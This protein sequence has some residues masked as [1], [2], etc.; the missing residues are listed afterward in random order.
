M[1]NWRAEYYA[2]VADYAVGALGMRVV[3][4]GGRSELER[5]VGEAIVARMKQPVENNIGQDTLLQLLATLERATI[6]L[7]PDSGPAHMA[8]AVGT[9]VIGLYA[10]TNPARSGPYLSRQW[11]VDKYDVAARRLL[12]KPAHELPWTTKIERPG[13]MDLITPDEVIRKLHAVL[14]ALSCAST[15]I[16]SPSSRALRHW[17]LPHCVTL[18]PCQRAATLP[19]TLL[20]IARN[21]AAHIARCLA[22]VPFAAEKLVVD[23][24]STDG[25]QA[26]AARHGARVVE[27]EWLGFGPQRNFAAHASQSRLDPV[28]DADEELTP[29]LARELQRELAEAACTR[30][31]PARSC[32]AKRG[33]WA[34]RCAGIDRWSARARSALSSRPRALDRC[35]RA[36][37]VALRRTRRSRSARPFVIITTRHSYTSSSRCCCTRSS[38][39]SI[40]WIASAAAQMWLTPFVGFGAFFKD[41]VLRLAFLD[42]WRGYI[43]ARVAASYAVYKRMRYYEMLR[44]PESV[45]LARS[46]SAASRT[47]SLNS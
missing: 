28:L 26:I 36:R 19:I 33:T 21:E 17:S 1:R 41:Y 12:G 43:V 35:A 23:S 14:L 45:E 44:N 13:V 37:V 4:C 8:S 40:G 5:R 7:T 18:S 6:L 10:A 16:E 11:C 24:G 47:G 32:D 34:R 2:Q 20:V 38:N 9:P 30:T 22:S 27:Q 39:H 42:G 3:L 46:A 15:G 29:E 31:R 25:T